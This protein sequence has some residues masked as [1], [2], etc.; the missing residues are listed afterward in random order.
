MTDEELDDL[1]VLLAS[2]GIGTA[3]AIEDMNNVRARAYRD[4]ALRAGLIQERK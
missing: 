2:I 3:D 1:V 4:A